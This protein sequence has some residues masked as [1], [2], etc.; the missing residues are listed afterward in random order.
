MKIEKNFRRHPR[1]AE[2]AMTAVG[3]KAEMFRKHIEPLA[4]ERRHE[5][6]R[7]PQRAKDR[8]VEPDSENAAELEIQKRKIERR[9]MRDHHRVAKESAK[10]WQYIFNPRRLAHHFIAD[11]SETGDKAGNRAMRP[12]QALK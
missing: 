2:S 8:I 11:R 3:R 1:V 6:A 4:P 10:R 9:V 7:H 12:H 5:A